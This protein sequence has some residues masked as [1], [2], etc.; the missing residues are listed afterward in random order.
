MAAR[1]RLPSGYVPQRVA[2]PGV[3]MR[4]AYHVA[5]LLQQLD[6]PVQAGDAEQARAALERAQH[7]DAVQQPGLPLDP[8]A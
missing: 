3:A 2:P 6:A 5:R 7:D 4:S 1:K 8:R